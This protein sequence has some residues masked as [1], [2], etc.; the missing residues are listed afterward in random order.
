[1]RRYATPTG[2]FEITRIAW[3]PWWYPPDAEWAA[4]D[5]VTAPG[6]GNPMG[7]VKLMFNG[8]YYLHGTPL[9]SSIGRAASHGCVR[10]RDEDAVE[11]ARIVQKYGGV[12]V[13]EPVM[14]SLM[15]NWKKTRLFRLA[16]FIPVTI[17]YRTAEV[18]DSMLSL[19]PDVY[20]RE[21]DA[22]YDRALA[23]LSAVGIPSSAVDTYA[24]RRFAGRAARSVVTVPL[25]Q[26]LGLAAPGGLS[27]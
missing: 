16:R 9:A 8:P 24:V 18:R 5:T 2:D 22:P 17:V 15:V 1:M 7:K 4:Q 19:Y 6:P 21:R 26:V 3:N 27:Q 14:D 10:M 13:S 20:R 23:A 12:E 25:Q 11:L